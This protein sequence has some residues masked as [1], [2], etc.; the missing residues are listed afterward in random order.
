MPWR[1][2]LIYGNSLNECIFLSSD[3]YYA[4]F[5]NKFAKEKWKILLTNEWH[6]DYQCM[7]VNLFNE[8]F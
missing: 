2:V 3:I 5:E 6:S 1:T 7:I 4:S 8:T